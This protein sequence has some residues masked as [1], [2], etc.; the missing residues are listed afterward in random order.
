MGISNTKKKPCEEKQ[1]DQ[2]IISNVASRCSSS[3][4][5][6]RR[7]SFYLIWL[8]ECAKNE[9]L[10]SLRTQALLREINHD[11]CLFF[12]QPDQFF[13]QIRELEERQQQL[14]VV[15]SGSLAEELLPKLRSIDSIPIIIIFCANY[16]QYVYLLNKYPKVVR[17]CTTYEKL[18]SSIRNELLSSKFNLFENQFI[19]YIRPL[20]SKNGIENHSAYYSYI[21]FIQLLKQMPQTEQAKENYKADKAIDWYVAECFVYRL[22]NHAFRTEDITLWYAFRYYVVDLCQQMEKIHQEQAIR[23]LLTVYRGQAR[24]PISQFE[25]LKCNIDCLVSTNGFFS[26]STHLDI[27]RSFVEG[28]TDTNNSKAVLFEITVD[29]FNLQNTIFVDIDRY[30]NSSDEGEGEGEGEVLFNIG[31]VFCIQDVIRHS[32]FDVWMIKMK[33]TDEGTDEIKKNLYEKKKEF[34][35][36]NINLLFGRLLI[37][38][39]EYCKAELYFRMLL[40]ELPRSHQDIPLAYDYIGDLNMRSSNWNEAFHNF[41]LGYEIKK[42]FFSSNHSLIAV[43]LN[44]IANYYKAIGDYSQALQYYTKALHCNNDQPT[45]ARIQVN[46][47]VIHAN[48]KKYGEA[49][50]LC[51]KAREILQQIYPQPYENTI[52]IQGILGHCHAQNKEY[53]I[54]E[55]YYVAAFKM[56][57]KVLSIGHRL[58]V[59]CIKALADLYKERGMKQIAI[60]L[61]QDNLFLYKKYLPAHHISIAYLFV[62]LGELYED[63]DIRKIAS[64]RRALRIFERS[65]FIEY[66]PTANCLLMIAEYYKNQNGYDSASKYYNRALKIQEKIYP[67]N[68]SII[69]Q[70]QSL[71]ATGQN[72]T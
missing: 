2:L 66:V 10:E 49:I 20:N 65:L 15:I 59:N 1:T 61:C 37:E 34:R 54:A 41:N 64:L 51:I 71:N 7:E 35:Q 70:T 30:I 62:K 27:A 24:M 44:N 43:S 25:H 28:D 33:A 42:K 45:M 22:V 58:R 50:D 19:K 52:Y 32:S 60:D 36:E 3:V 48:N 11:N 14:L 6:E 16:N 63:D 4:N 38:M 13:V 21:S 18:Q 29:G 69:L 67:N 5:E 9:S 26:T 53:S 57:E 46:I 31:S 39:N 40:Q 8:D 17:I 68:H 72:Q 23:S 12:N 56:S 55:D 47:A